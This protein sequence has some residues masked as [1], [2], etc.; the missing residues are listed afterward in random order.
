MFRRPNYRWHEHPEPY[1][2]G[3][4]LN[5]VLPLTTWNKSKRL[6]Y[7]ILLSCGRI[8]REINAEK[9]IFLAPSK[10]KA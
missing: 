2:Y 1:L 5:K 9:V 3:M 6:K 4:V 7:D 10:K 8:F